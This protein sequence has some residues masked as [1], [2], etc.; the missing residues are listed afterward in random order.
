MVAA[1][2]L[3]DSLM[4]RYR[5]SLAYSGTAPDGFAAI[6]AVDWR[7]F[8]IFTTSAGV[9]YLK[10]QCLAAEQ[11]DTAVAWAPSGGVGAS[12]LTLEWSADDVTYTTIGVIPVATDGTITWYDFTSVTV[13]LNGW[14]R[15][16]FTA[17]SSWRLL[18]VGKR[19]LF[20]IGQWSGLNPLTLYQGIVRENVIAV[21]GSI[22]GSNMRR[23]QKQATISLQYLDPAW[24]RA[25]WNPFAIHAGKRPFWYRWDPIGHPTEI[26]FASASDINAPTNDRPPPKM[27]VDLPIVAITD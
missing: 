21:N 6:N 22:L 16:A 11:I 8:S 15:F 23:T 4:Y 27:K 7:D 3:W 14:I 19:L 18:S 24:V 10:V 12:T 20:P 1:Q 2:V 9:T 5:A 17:V 13:P 25:T 26:A